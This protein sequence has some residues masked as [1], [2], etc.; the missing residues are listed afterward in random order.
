VGASPVDAAAVTGDVLAARRYR[1]VAPGLVARIAGDEA[2]KT[3]SRSEAVKR[4][5][6]RLHQVIGAYATEIDVPHALESLRVAAGDGDEAL[7][8]ACREVMGR[9]ASTKERLPVLD[10]FY[11]DIFAVTGNPARVLDLACGLGPLALPWMGLPRHARYVACDADR[12]LVELVDGFL[13]L[14]GVDHTVDLCDIA[15]DAPHAPADVAL[16]L[17]TLPC[18]DQQASDA[19]RRLLEELDAQWLV[20]SYPAKSLGGVEKGMVATYRRQFQTVVEGLGTVEKELLFP[21]ELV[22][23]VKSASRVR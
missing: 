18:L 22:Y 6:R 1:S 15:G 20:I 5:K 11:E 16:V 8:A 4:T 7:R 17:K 13:T 14:G 10:H 9:H 19:G 3:R 23:V 2:P 12:Q 21:T